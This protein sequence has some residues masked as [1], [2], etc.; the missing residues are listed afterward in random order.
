MNNSKPVDR[1]LRAGANGLLGWP[2]SWNV[3]AAYRYNACNQPC[4]MLV[5]PCVCG[6]WHTTDEA[7]VRL[8][9]QLYGAVII[10]PTPSYTPAPSLS[11]F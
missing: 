6:A 10:F 2:D 7:W 9:L 11:Y 1:V 5:G 8:S 4:D 3:P